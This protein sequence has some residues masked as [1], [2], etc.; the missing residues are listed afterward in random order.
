MRSTRQNTELINYFRIKTDLGAAAKTTNSDDIE[1]HLDEL[2][3]MAMHT[4][5]DRLRRACNASIANHH[6]SP[7]AAAIHA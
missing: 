6:H 1:H 5:S 3:I 4:T 2:A 7:P